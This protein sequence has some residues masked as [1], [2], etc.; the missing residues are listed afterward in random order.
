VKRSRFELMGLDVIGR[1]YSG[2]TATDLAIGDCTF[3]QCNFDLLKVTGACF[4]V[5]SGS[6]FIECTFNKSVISSHAVGTVTFDK[7][8][9]MDVRLEAWISTEADYIGCVFSGVLFKGVFS[10]IGLSGRQNNILH[11]DFSLMDLRDVTF[12]RGINLENQLFPK[13]SDLL[14]LKN[15][16]KVFEHAATLIRKLR[17]SNDR[18][19][20]ERYLESYR[21]AFHAGQREILVIPKHHFALEHESDRLFVNILREANTHPMQ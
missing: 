21:H 16:P 11:N 20:C 2:V 18:A 3:R 15:L 4:G 7:C 17:A 19:I 12:S 14:I 10:A 9:F 5:G 6:K 13:N 8:M 1:D